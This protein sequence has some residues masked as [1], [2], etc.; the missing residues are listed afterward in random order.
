MIKTNI[1]R[2]FLLFGSHFP[3]GA[4]RGALFEAP[5]PTLFPEVLSPVYLLPCLA[6]RRSR[7]FVDFISDMVPSLSYY[8]ACLHGHFGRQKAQCATHFFPSE[9][10]LPVLVHR[11]LSASPSE[12]RLIF[13]ALGY[14]DRCFQSP[15]AESPCAFFQNLVASEAESTQ[16]ATALNKSLD[17]SE[18]EA[19]L[20]MLSMFGAPDTDGAAEA[21]ILSFTPSVASSSPQRHLSPP[22]S[23]SSSMSSVGTPAS[24][25]K[26]KKDAVDK[27]KDKDRDKPA[28]PKKKKKRARETNDVKNGDTNKEKLYCICRK[29]YDPGVF[30]IGCDKCD[31]WF[32][33]ECVHVSSKDAKKMSSYTCSACE[34]KAKEEAAR[35]E[36]MRL[37]EERRQQLLLQQQALQQQ[38][39]R[40]PKTEQPCLFGKCGDFAREGSSYCSHECGI[41][42]SMIQVERDKQDEAAQ[43]KRDEELTRRNMFEQVQAR[44][45]RQHELGQVLPIL[46]QHDIFILQEVRRELQKIHEKRG[47]LEQQRLYFQAAVERARALPLQE[48]STNASASNGSV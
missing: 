19:A 18:D 12:A 48:A 21:G 14:W 9:R 26:E 10:G 35:K 17:V 16:G 5:S 32:H 23:S 31:D 46:E 7:R 43:R 47:L 37:E 4:F 33:G 6:T 2:P 41:R 45:L 28:K 34:K 13:L 36:R 39:V 42:Y 24:M 3:R 22:P 25:K 30:M 38:K 15:V 44:I 27:D 20:A 8:F 29:P 11:T 40:V 1:Y